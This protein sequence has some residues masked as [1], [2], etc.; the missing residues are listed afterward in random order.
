MLHRRCPPQTPGKV[1]PQLILSVCGLLER[2]A[3]VAISAVTAPGLAGSAGLSLLR[4]LPGALASTA[5]PLAVPLPASGPLALVH[6]ADALVFITP[7]LVH[8]LGEG[9]VRATA[10]PETPGVDE[11]QPVGH[12]Y[13][14]SF[15][16]RVGC[17]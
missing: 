1:H 16:V 7:L 8:L 9:C 3:S 15:S 12:M 14:G 4:G 5:P 11:V 13:W 17:W 6:L 10:G 2:L